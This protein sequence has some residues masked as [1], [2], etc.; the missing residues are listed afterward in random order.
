MLIR[1]TQKAKL[2]DVVTLRSVLMP[3]VQIAFT[4]DHSCLSYTQTF[5]TNCQ[6]TAQVHFRVCELW[7]ALLEVLVNL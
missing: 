1:L 3:Q 5:V 7:P 4:K 6:H 2:W